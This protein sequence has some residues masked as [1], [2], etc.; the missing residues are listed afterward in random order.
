MRISRRMYL[1]VG[2]IA[3]LVLA[4]CNGQRLSNEE[5]IK[6]MLEANLNANEEN[7]P[8]TIYEQY[9]PSQREGCPYKAFLDQVINGGTGE[10]D[11]SLSYSDF[12]VEIMD[13]RAEAT[14][15]L[16]LDGTTVRDKDE[17]LVVFLREGGSWYFKMPQVDLDACRRPAP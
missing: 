3:I 1:L 9:A 13:D 6:Q 17:P 15:A 12:N 14:Y 4:A 8:L 5:Q 11:I 7:D 10:G 16:Q 2:L